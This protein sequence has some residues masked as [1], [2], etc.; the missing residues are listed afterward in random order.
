MTFLATAS[1]DVIL[2]DADVL[3]IAEKGSCTPYA[4]MCGEELIEDLMDA[5]TFTIAAT[6]EV[7]ELSDAHFA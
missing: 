6:D 5:P 3:Y 7:Q 2:T 4:C 1:A